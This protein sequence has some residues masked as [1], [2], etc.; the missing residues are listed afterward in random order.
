MALSFRTSHYFVS[1][2]SEMG[3][4]IAGYKDDKC[5]PNEWRYQIVNPLKVELPSSL[6]SVV[7]NWNIPMHMFL[8]KCKQFFSVY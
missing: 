4:I 1:Y 6:V 7:T 5:P 8:K 3:M 2:L